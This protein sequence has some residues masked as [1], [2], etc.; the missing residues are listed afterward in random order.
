MN[1]F[2][3]R[4]DAAAKKRLDPGVERGEFHNIRCEACL[5]IIPNYRGPNP[6][7]ICSQCLGTYGGATRIKPLAITRSAIRE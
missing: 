4:F 2:L 1:L 5:S 3:R 6:G 7:V